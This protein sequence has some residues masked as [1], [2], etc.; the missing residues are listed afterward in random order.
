MHK[1]T[2]AQ[3]GAVLRPTPRGLRR[4]GASRERAAGHR[5]P[6]DSQARG[7]GRAAQ[8]RLRYAKQV[9]ATQQL[10]YLAPAVF[11]DPRLREGNLPAACRASCGP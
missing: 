1:A 8:S 4:G 9:P 3:G 6:L 2:Q 11:L 10:E 7:R 5:S